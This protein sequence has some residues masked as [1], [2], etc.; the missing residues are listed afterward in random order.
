MKLIAAILS[1]L[2]FS[3]IAFSLVYAQTAT[4][5]ATLRTTKLDNLTERSATREANLKAKLLKFKDQRKAQTTER[6][7]TNLA[8][9][10]KNRTDMMMVHLD[11]MSNI[12]IRLEGRVG[13]ITDKDTTM[14]KGEIASAS[15][16]IATAKEAVASQSAK[17]YTIELTTETNVRRDAQA[18]RES[19]HADLRSVHQLVVDARQALSKAISETAKLGGIKNGQQ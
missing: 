5:P 3:S 11:R 10:N 14:A 12:L 15:A 17:D 16:T 9:V 13:N 18:S 4:S 1:F 6:V 7:N 2:V 19:L 8:K